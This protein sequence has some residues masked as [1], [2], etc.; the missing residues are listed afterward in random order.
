MLSADLLSFSSDRKP[1]N[2]YLRKALLEKFPREL[3]F[4]PWLNLCIILTAYRRLRHDKTGT[5]ND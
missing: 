4:W 1:R 5:K 2:F 3:R